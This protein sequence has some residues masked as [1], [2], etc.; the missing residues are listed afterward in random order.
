MEQLVSDMT[1]FY[2]AVVAA[3]SRFCE[4]YMIF[5]ALECKTDYLIVKSYEALDQSEA[6]LE[7]FR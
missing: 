5:I 4:L 2:K 7:R 3:R 1:S 6:L